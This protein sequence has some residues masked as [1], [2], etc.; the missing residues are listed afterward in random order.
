[1]PIHQVHS[2]D[3]SPIGRGVSS[4]SR[5][6]PGQCDKRFRV[7]LYLLLVHVHVWLYMYVHVA[8]VCV[9]WLCIHVHLQN[10]PHVLVPDG[11]MLI[12]TLELVCDRPSY[13]CRVHCIRHIKVLVQG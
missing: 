10:V 1:M 2:G 13:Y 5:F 12:S 8:E 7:R 11:T 3:M 4:H 9:M 6:L